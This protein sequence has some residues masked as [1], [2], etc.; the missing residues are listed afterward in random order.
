MP[1]DPV[2]TGFVVLR[3]AVRRT[4]MRVLPQKVPLPVVNVRPEEEA[5]RS[6]AMLLRAL[7]HVRVWVRVLSSRQPLRHQEGPD[8]HSA[9]VGTTALLSRLIAADPWASA[10][11]SRNPFPAAPSLRVGIGVSAEPASAWA[12]LVRDTVAVLAPIVPYGGWDR[13]DR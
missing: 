1:S 6:V 9:R 12:D 11:A 7:A 10:S 4:Q 8:L 5:V 3:A 13:W 2:P